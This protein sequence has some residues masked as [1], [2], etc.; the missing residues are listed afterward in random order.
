MKLC[1]TVMKPHET[2][3]PGKFSNS[4][5]CLLLQAV[6]Q[7]QTTRFDV[8]KWHYLEIYIGKQRKRGRQIYIYSAPGD[9]VKSL[10]IFGLKVEGQPRDSQNR[11]FHRASSSDFLLG[12]CH[13]LP[14]HY[15]GPRTFP[16]W[17]GDVLEGLRR[18]TSLSDPRECLT[19]I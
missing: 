19:Y 8:S 7:Q 17:I 14:L 5:S 9:P 13:Y 1:E 15:F 11:F 2:T 18:L 6:Q 16:E 4:K 3:K 12:C 10:Q